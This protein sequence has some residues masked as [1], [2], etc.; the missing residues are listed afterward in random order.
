GGEGRHQNG[1]QADG[2]RL[3]YG[4][5]PGHALAA[6]AAGVVHQHNGVVD[7]DAHHRDQPHEGGGAEGAPRDGQAED[8]AHQGHGHRQ[9]DADGED[10]GLKLGRHN[11]VHQEEAHQGGD[12]QAAEGVGHGLL[13]AAHFDFVAGG[14]FNAVQGFLDRTHHSA[15]GPAIQESGDVGDAGLVGPGDGGGADGLL[16][17]G[18]GAQADMAA[19]GRGD[20]QGRDGRA[21]RHGAIIQA[22]GHVHLGAG[23]AKLGDGLPHH[24]GAHRLG[25][26]GGG[27]AQ[28]GGPLAVHHH[29]QFRQA[30]IKGSTHIPQAVDAFQPEGRFVGQPPQY[31]QII[32]LDG[33][34][35]GR[36]A[37]AA[38]AT[39]AHA[40][41]R[42][43]GVGDADAGAGHGGHKLAQLVGHGLG[44]PLPLVLGHQYDLHLTVAHGPAGAAGLAEPGRPAYV[45]EYL[46]GFRQAEG[47]SFQHAHYA[48]GLGQVGAGGEFGVHEDLPLIDAGEEFGIHY[49]GE[50]YGQHNGAAHGGRHLAA[51]AQGP[52]EKVPVVIGDARPAGLGLSAGGGAIGLVAGGAAAGLAVAVAVAAAGDGGHRRLAGGPLIA[53]FN[54]PHVAPPEQPGGQHGNAHNS[55]QQGSGQTERDGQGQVPEDLRRQTLQENHGQEHR[56]G[57]QGGGG[58]GGGHLVGALDGGVVGRQPLLA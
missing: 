43:G 29:P 21:V 34:G 58:D 42:G 53:V 37:E 46:F 28:G 25:Y 9:H 47:R 22:D 15:Q 26:L 51:V 36:A 41:A 44:G 1:P 32:A 19:E 38:A 6:Q 11:E 14:Q 3:D 52:D 31:I 17:M 39:A 5:V 12:G 48:V 33:D 4:L 57:G 50:E 55:Y 40:H 35:N 49:K 2:A 27:D 56:Q 45:G 13:L 23:I 30:F 7:D 10:V 24:G 18:H 20:G 54:N 16:Q 8:D